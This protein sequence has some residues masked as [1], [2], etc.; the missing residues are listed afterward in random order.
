MDVFR[1]TTARKTIYQE[2]T[3]TVKTEASR[4]TERDKSDKKIGMEMIDIFHV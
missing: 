4:R 1:A 2:E 3:T